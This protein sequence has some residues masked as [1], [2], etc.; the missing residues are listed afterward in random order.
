MAGPFVVL[1]LAAAAAALW[2]SVR[3]HASL[4]RRLEQRLEDV[5][6][7]PEPS[8]AP[9]PP[10]RTARPVLG[11][12]LQQQNGPSPLAT[13]KTLL[14]DPPLAAAAV[15][16]IAGTTL[17]LVAG[18]GSATRREGTEARIAGLQAAVDSLSASLTALR[19]SVRQPPTPQA[20]SGARDPVGAPR[21]RTARAASARP[22]SLPP[23]PSLDSALRAGP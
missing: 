5:A 1:V 16:V 23:A 6:K 15:L 4:L 22:P 3:R 21:P 12:I 18:P 7:P 11:A 20:D 2:L 9:G 17:A 14:G 13:L 10:A 19:D 8:P